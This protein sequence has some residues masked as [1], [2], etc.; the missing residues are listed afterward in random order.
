M[1]WRVT[2][3][4]SSWSGKGPEHLGYAKMFRLFPLPAGVRVGRRALLA[5]PP[6]DTPANAPAPVAQVGFTYREGT[7]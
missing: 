4:D 2:V 1:G 6:R 5:S 7:S 3:A